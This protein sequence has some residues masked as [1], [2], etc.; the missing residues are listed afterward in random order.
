MANA[1]KTINLSG[2]RAMLSPPG[3]VTLDYNNTLTISIG[4]GFPTG[5]E[6]ARLQFY[7]V[8]NHQKGGTLLGAWKRNANS[9]VPTGVLAAAS[10]TGVVLTDSDTTNADED[11]YYNVRV[12]DAAGQHWDADPEL[13]LKKRAQTGAARSTPR[14]IAPDA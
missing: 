4:T 14:D 5:A 9:N 13:V 11:Y 1:T 12:K 6:I 7:N 10:G 2:G 3:S 8:N